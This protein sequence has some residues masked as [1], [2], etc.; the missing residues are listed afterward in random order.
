MR[1]IPRL[2]D[3]LSRSLVELDGILRNRPLLLRLA[4]LAALFWLLQFVSLWAILSGG[5]LS[6]DLAGAAVVAGAA[7][8]GSTLTFLPLGTQDG[9]SAV[10][11]KAFGAP[12][13]TG[14]ALAL[15]HTALSLV[16][17]AALVVLMPWFGMKNVAAGESPR[18]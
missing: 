13:A 10:V 2:G 6:I 8:L 7:I 18:D 12:L 3:A 14:F 4:A 17:S 15:F 5:G 9:I 11:L 16:C 1:R